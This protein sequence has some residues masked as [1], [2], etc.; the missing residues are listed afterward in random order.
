[1]QIKNDI[2]EKIKKL[3][4]GLIN[5]LDHYLDYLINKGN[6][7]RTGKLKQ[8][9]AGDLNDIKISSLELQKLALDWRKK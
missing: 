5:E 1:M 8:N 3:S 4:P 7:R 2:E 6:S 9:W